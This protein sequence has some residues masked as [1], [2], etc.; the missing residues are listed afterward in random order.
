MNVESEGGCGEEEDERWEVRARCIYSELRLSPCSSATMN[1]EGNTGEL[2][3]LDVIM[4]C[5][6]FC[7]IVLLASLRSNCALGCRVVSQRRFGKNSTLKGRLKGQV[8][9]RGS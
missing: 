8:A 3:Q 9:K 2:R 6:A 5:R 4:R 7:E 1:A